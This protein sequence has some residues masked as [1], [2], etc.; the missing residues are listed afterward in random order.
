MNWRI[1]DHGGITAK[2]T[3]I[4]QITVFVRSEAWNFLSKGEKTRGTKAPKT[5]EQPQGNLRVLYV[6]GAVDGGSEGGIF[7]AFS[8]TNTM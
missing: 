2:G 7:F 4:Y 5:C 1:P 3:T 6:L 8:W